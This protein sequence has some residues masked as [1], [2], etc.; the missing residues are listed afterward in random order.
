MR[1][2]HKAFGNITKRETYTDFYLEVELP[3]GVAAFRRQ[4]ILNKVLELFPKLYGHT[5]DQ[6]VL[7][8]ERQLARHM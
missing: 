3:N 7:D 6:M 1:R 5:I 2:W 8:L 4:K